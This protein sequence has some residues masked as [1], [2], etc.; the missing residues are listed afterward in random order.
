[1]LSGQSGST[2]EQFLDTCVALL[3]NV[4][5]WPSP[6]E[7]ACTVAEECSSAR[8]LCV[9]SGLRL[10]PHEVPPALSFQ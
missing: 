8:V 6:R 7:R 10:P 1:M 2:L 9:A 5:P 3:E 4:L